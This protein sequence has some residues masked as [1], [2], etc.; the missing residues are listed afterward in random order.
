MIKCGQPTVLQM[1]DHFIGYI[2]GFTSKITS[3]KWLIFIYWR[4][5]K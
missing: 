1:A 5:T 3:I 2:W 4:K